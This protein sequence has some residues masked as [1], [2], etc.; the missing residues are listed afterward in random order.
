MSEQ[1]EQ[2]LQKIITPYVFESRR[3]KVVEDIR[4][5]ISD[6][7]YICVGKDRVILPRWLWHDMRAKCKHLDEIITSGWE[8]KIKATYPPRG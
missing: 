5:A 4:A 7:G 6:E 8:V 1:L 2:E 3:A